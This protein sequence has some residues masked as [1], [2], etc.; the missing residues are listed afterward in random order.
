MGRFFLPVLILGLLL[1][2][3]MLS[4]LFELAGEKLKTFSFSAIIILTIVAVLFIA[5]A[6]YNSSEKEAQR[7]RGFER[8]LVFKMKEYEKWFRAKQ[9]LEN[10]K[11]T[12]AASTIGAL[13]YY[14]D[15]NVIDLIG[16]TDSYI[17]HHPK[18]LKGIDKRISVLWRERYYNADYV[19]ARKPDFIVFPADIKP[20]AYPE[21]AIFSSV[22]FLNNYYV[23]LIPSEKVG[24]Y[25]PVF[26]RITD[27]LRW[28]APLINSKCKIM[29]TEDFILANNNFLAFL[30]YREGKYF[31]EVFNYADILARNCPA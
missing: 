14:S 28:F 6:S 30:K 16:L 3:L 5:T 19:L 18:E 15:A 9:K 23:K 4:D 20:S 12:L 1:F 24:Q 13:S 8:G 10:K 22:D 17:A 11:I 25:L 26:S 31:D 2:A 29:A 21:A 27:S 7:W